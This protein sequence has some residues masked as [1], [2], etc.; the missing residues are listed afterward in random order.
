M[1][2]MPA[3]RRARATTFAPRSC[4]SKPG[5]AIRTRIFLGIGTTSVKE[6]LLPGAEDLAHHVADFTEG[7]LRA[8][9]V[10]DERHRVL[11][12]L[13]CLE[14]TLE[15]L[16]VLLRVPSPAQLPKAFDLSL[17]RRLRH[18]ERLDLRLF[19]DDEIVDADDDPL[20]VLDFPLVSIRGV[21]DFLLEEP[22]P[23]RGDH[24][25]E[26]GNP[27]EVA[28]CFRLQ[29]VRQRFEEV[30]AAERVDRVGHPALVR[31][32][33]LGPQRNPR[34]PLVRN[35]VR[36]V[37]GVCVEG[38]SAPED[39]RER[40]DRRPDDVHLRLLR[41][42]AH[43]RRLRV[44]PQTPRPRVLGT[45]RVAHLARPDA[46]R[47]AIFR[48]LLEEIVM[49][50]EEKRKAWREVVDFQTAVD[51]PADVLH[52][53]REG[54]REFL[55][56]GRAR[57]A[58][59]IPA[60]RNRV[61][62]GNVL[63]AEFERLHDDP[64]R[65]LRRIDPLLLGL[66]LLQDVVL[67]RPPKPRPRHPT[68]FRP[69]DVHRP[70][71]GGRAV[72]RHRRADAADIDPAE[73]DPHVLQRRHGDAARPELPF[74]LRLVRVIS[75]EGRHVERDAEAGLAVGDQI[76]E[77]AV[78]VRRA[79]HSG[80]HPH[81]PQPAAVHGGMDAAGEWEPAGA[82]E[83]LV[84]LPGDVERRVQPPHRPTG[85]R[86]EFL[87]AFRERFERLAKGGL[88][89]PLQLLFEDLP[90]V[91]VPH[92]RPACF[93]LSDAIRRLWPLTGRSSTR[94][95]SWRALGRL[96]RR[97]RR[98]S[99]T[100]RGPGTRTKAAWTKPPPWSLRGGGRGPS[101]FRARTPERVPRSR[102]PRRST[103][104]GLGAIGRGSRRTPR[105]RLSLRGSRPP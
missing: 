73:Q 3:S 68:A 28:V 31:E 87:A 27:V 22:F 36:V 57:L 9:G 52:P 37:E 44:Q 59:V 67:N 8:Y 13:A 26:F 4:P 103:S 23:N 63:R 91:L 10:E 24:A 54:E 40:L 83:P 62:F 51:A 99:R 47:R 69:P 16:L 80:E 2:S 15:R 78:R 35:L 18:A 19:V 88:L 84:R 38:L 102:E 74:R 29:L 100:C 97:S 92:E 66:V 1:T 42:Q 6:R 98:S 85:G 49:G 94:R 95:S 76:L 71:D 21:R 53:V 96:A 48:E 50:V 12:R 11:V 55:R 17:E 105:G 34:G 75:V 39:S 90:L 41:G 46:T 86:D 81:R 65:R 5:F 64:P 43:A 7:R 101:C 45:E 58:D 61:P 20:F 89:P 82:A 79:P 72:D 93:Q 60:D 30:G 33:L 77:S 56:R 14:E 32:D 104:S 25:P 70:D